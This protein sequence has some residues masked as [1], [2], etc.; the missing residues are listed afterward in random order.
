MTTAAEERHGRFDWMIVG[1][2]SESGE[3][4]NASDM[5]DVWSVGDD[6]WIVIVL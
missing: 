4:R 3:E 1:P 6:V 2:A 5:D